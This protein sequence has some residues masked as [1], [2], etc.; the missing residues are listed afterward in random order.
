[1]SK[2]TKH[3]KIWGECTACDLC[4]QRRNVCLY[5][6]SIPCEVLFL[7]EAPGR[8]EDT[9]GKPFSGPAGK[10][11][12]HIIQ[13]SMP[14]A[15][16][17]ITNL[18]GC[19][20]KDDTGSKVAEPPKDSI[21]I[22]SDRVL[23]IYEMAKPKLTVLVGKLAQKHF[24]TYVYNYTDIETETIGITHPASILRAD[25]TVKQMNIDKCVCQLREAYNDVVAPF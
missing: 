3:Q 6:G 7:G 25:E 2:W 8:A 11:L 17:G 12:D 23:E 24:P 19:I 18:V 14:E 4:Q 10:L 15:T 5:R 9:I 1:M 22:C 20:P 13:Q 16:I 21:I